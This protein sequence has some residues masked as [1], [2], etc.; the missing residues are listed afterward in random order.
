M[1]AAALPDNESERL[2]ALH[3]YRILGTRPEQSFDDITAIASETCQ[4]PIALL[5]LVDS[6]RQWFKSKVGLDAD[7]TPRDWSFC[8]HA[9]L[10]SEPLIVQDALK[11]GLENGEGS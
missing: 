4:V 6:D 7:E 2:L 9:I 5:S 11:D 1:K 10:S 8:A 3:E